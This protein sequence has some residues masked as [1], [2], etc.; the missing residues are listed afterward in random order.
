M[1]V[2]SFSHSFLFRVALSYVRS[3]SALD[4][5][6]SEVFPQQRGVVFVVLDYIHLWIS[7][8]ASASGLFLSGLIRRQ[9]S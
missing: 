9:S 5:R 8:R 7:R 3:I 1:T 4:K 6:S 2:M